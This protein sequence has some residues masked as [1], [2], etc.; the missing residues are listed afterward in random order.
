MRRAALIVCSAAHLP[1]AERRRI[2]TL[3]ATAP[4]G[5]DGRVE[6]AHPDLVIEPYA[7][8]FFVHTCVV[9]CGAERPDDISAQFWAILTQAFD[10]DVSWILFDRDEP[11]S[12]ELPVFSDPDRPEEY[13]S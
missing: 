1:V 6:V 12:P 11:V 4:R 5:D 7:Y 3:I 10:S 2:D 13:M 9:G 8:G